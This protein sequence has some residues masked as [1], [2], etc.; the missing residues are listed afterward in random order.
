MTDNAR[1][2]IAIASVEKLLRKSTKKRKPKITKKLKVK[3]SK[4]PV[5]PGLSPIV[6][7][8]KAKP[9]AP[10]KVRAS[11]IVATAAEWE[12][13]YK[14]VAAFENLR[15][16]KRK[17]ATGRIDADEVV[18]AVVEALRKKRVSIHLAT[19]IAEHLRDELIS[20]DMNEAMGDDGDAV[21]MAPEEFT[22]A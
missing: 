3:K 17:I 6:I 12:K 15:A 11:T 8:K 14:I 19:L 2:N 7:K 10:A 16:L 1:L 20:I 9:K 5:Q 22:I 18:N 4:V 21:T 13:A